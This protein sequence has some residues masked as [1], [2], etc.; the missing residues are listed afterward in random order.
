MAAFAAEAPR[1]MATSPSGWK[2]FWSAMGPTMMGVKC[3]SPSR[4]AVRSRSRVGMFIR[5]RSVMRSV[6]V[7]SLPRMGAAFS[8]PNARRACVSYSSTFTNS[9]RG[10]CTGGGVVTRSGAGAC[11]CTDMAVLATPAETAAPIAPMA[12][13]RE[14]NIACKRPFPATRAKSS[15]VMRNHEGSSPRISGHAHLRFRGRLSEQPQSAA[16]L[17]DQAMNTCAKRCR[18]ASATSPPRIFRILKVPLMTFCTR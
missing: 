3:W 17:H 4:A 11:A 9:P 10:T 2:R 16:Q 8:A 18:K 12:W 5:G 14:V 7:R 1:A 15:F 6:M 13:R